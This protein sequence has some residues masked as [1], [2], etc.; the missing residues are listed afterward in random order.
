MR[1][2]L[3]ITLILLALAA[4]VTISYFG[5]INSPET[6]AASIINYIPDN[7]PV[8][9]EFSN[10]NSFYD[11]LKDDTLFNDVIGREKLGDLDTL[12][13]TIVQNP[14][15][16]K[17]FAG[18]QLYISVYPTTEKQVELLLTISAKK[19]FNLSVINQ[20]AKRLNTGITI[21][22]LDAGGKHAYNF[23]L[24]DLKKSLYLVNTYE[25]V[26]SCSFSNELVQQAARFVPLKNHSSFITLPDQQ[27]ASALAALYINYRA[28]EPLFSLLFKNRST[29]IFREFR[30]FNGAA[31]LTLNYKPDALMFNGTTE[32]NSGGQSGYLSTFAGQQPVVNH[33]KDIFPSTSAYGVNF[34]IP[35]RSG[36]AKNLSAF[37]AKS[38]QKVNRQKLFDQI[39]AETGIN[40]PARFYS[41]I[42]NEF[43]LVTTKYF[44]K[45]GIIALNDGAQMNDLLINLSKISDVNA[46]QFIYDNLPLYL[47]GDNFGVF[48]HPYFV[49]LDNYLVL[50]NSVGELTSYKDSYYNRK[51]LSKSSQY[52]QLDNLIAA[53]STVSFF[54][55]F[56]N[57]EPIFKRDMNDDFYKLFEPGEGRWGNFY[58][59]SWQ[60]SAVDKNFYT[61]FCLRLNRDTSTT[62][63]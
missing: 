54:L 39:K 31:A 52:Q 50:A 4:Y 17:Y 55:V 43:A 1:K 19:E 23:Y 58:G 41:L 24:H 21:A 18:Q 5:D 37:F 36:F 8:V 2:H 16:N 47:L 3:I 6:H 29:D 44:E 11:I 49:I 15:L 27:N 13:K 63:N 34:S 12:R 33:L 20:L 57:A 22:P 56:K 60:L 45:L 28:F 10:D 53:Q 32:M 38:P 61:N 7:T 9:F 40:M 35:N 30:T 59:V 26:F 25:N 42:G 46:G 51:F 62:K 14:F 48:K